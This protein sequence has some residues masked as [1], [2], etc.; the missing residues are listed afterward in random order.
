MTGKPVGSGNIMPYGVAIG[1]ALSK[2][3]A[4]TDELVALRDHAREILESQ[5]D[6]AAALKK[7]E[8]EIAKRGYKK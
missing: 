5:G 7:L 8:A 3:S 1:N 6:L 2:G 4:S